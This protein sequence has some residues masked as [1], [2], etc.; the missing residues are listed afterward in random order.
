VGAAEPSRRS[1]QP[2]LMRAETEFPMTRRRDDSSDQVGRSR[3]AQLERAGTRT[4]TTV[5]DRE[6]AK[7]KARPHMLGEAE[8]NNRLV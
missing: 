7:K 4:V 6:Y 1:S 5:T 8:L 2:L 3:V